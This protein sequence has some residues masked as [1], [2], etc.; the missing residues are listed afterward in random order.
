VMLTPSKICGLTH[1]AHD[2]SSQSLLN[3]SST[4]RTTVACQCP[5][6]PNKSFGSSDRTSAKCK[7]TNSLP[8][9]LPFQQSN[10]RG[11]TANRKTPPSAHGPHQAPNQAKHSNFCSAKNQ[12]DP[13]F[14]RSTIVGPPPKRSRKWTNRRN[15]KV[16]RDQV[17]PQDRTSTIRDS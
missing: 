8:K 3:P 16:Q 4:E 11:P 1:K 10:V 6:R 5:L 9:R 17:R 13:K 12:R 7:P 2:G 14:V 15:A